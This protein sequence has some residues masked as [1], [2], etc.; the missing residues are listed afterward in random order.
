MKKLLLGNCFALTATT[1]RFCKHQ[2]QNISAQNCLDIFS[3]GAT[4]T[5]VHTPPPVLPRNCSHPNPQN[6]NV[7]DRVDLPAWS[8]FI[9]HPT[10]YKP[11]HISRDCLNLVGGGGVPAS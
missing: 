1:L 11:G 8:Y 2:I 7:K 6:E 3:N 10:Q 4:W 5:G 9:T